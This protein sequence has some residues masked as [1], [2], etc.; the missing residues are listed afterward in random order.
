ML[1]EPPMVQVAVIGLALLCVVVLFV[2]ASS[3]EAPKRRR[4]YRRAQFRETCKSHG[5][6]QIGDGQTPVGQRGARLTKSNLR[7][8]PDA[9]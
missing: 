6:S 7:S 4:M 5:R 8:R 3:P 9:S 1:H 2:A